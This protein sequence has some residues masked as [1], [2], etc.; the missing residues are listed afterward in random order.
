MLANG[1]RRKTRISRH[2]QEEGVV[3]GEE[4]LLKYITSYYKGL[5]GSSERNNFSMNESM[6]EDIPQVTLIENDWLTA[7]FLEN[8]VR[9]AIFQMKHNKAPGSD[10]FLAEFYQVCW[11]LIKNDLMSLFRDFHAGNLLLSTLILEL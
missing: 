2:E 4:Q 6:R 10:G 5:F 7:E 1:K 8:E 11:S 3:E 9:E